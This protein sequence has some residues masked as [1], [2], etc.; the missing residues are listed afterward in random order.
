MTFLKGEK[1]T[2]VKMFLNFLVD[3]IHYAAWP[4]VVIFTLI[5]F[6]KPFGRLIDRIKKLRSKDLFVDFAGL[7]AEV[8]KKVGDKV[9]LLDVTKENLN[10]EKF[11]DAILELGISVATFA[12]LVRE[13]DE[14]HPLLDFGD[15]MLKIVADKVKAER[16]TDWRLKFL[17]TK[18]KNVRPKDEQKE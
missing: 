13:F 16:P 17:I 3:I 7:P 1:M 14:K 5:F 2:W 15:E 12:S 11:L 6:S 10:Y 4:A 9:F 8:Q 18:L